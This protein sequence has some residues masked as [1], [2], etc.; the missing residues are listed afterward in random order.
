[1]KGHV[2]WAMPSRGRYGKIGLKAN[3]SMEDILHEV[4]HIVDYQEGHGGGMWDSRSA[5]ISGETGWS[6][7]QI[8]H[9]TMGERSSSSTE[10]RYRLNEQERREQFPR[11]VAGEGRSPIV[12]VTEDPAI[13]PR[14]WDIYNAAGEDTTVKPPPQGSTEGSHTGAG[15]GDVLNWKKSKVLQ[16]EKSSLPSERKRALLDAAAVS[17]AASAV[18]GTNVIVNA[19]STS[20]SNSTVQKIDANPLVSHNPR[21]PI[22]VHYG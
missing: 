21:R 17:G 9:G 2:A 22:G 16:M 14:G 6:Q 12:V 3:A 7:S 20:N 10:S 19:P 18:G 5:V 13:H 8:Y 1:M 15:S 11:W 4:Q